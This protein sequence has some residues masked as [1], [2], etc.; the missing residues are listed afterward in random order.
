MFGTNEMVLVRATFIDAR[1]VV[2]AIHVDSVSLRNE[3]IHPST[4]ADSKAVRFRAVMSEAG[5][6]RGTKRRAKC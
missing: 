6:W 2:Y 3:A 4:F 1:Y 5:G